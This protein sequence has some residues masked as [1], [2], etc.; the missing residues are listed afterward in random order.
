MEQFQA[1]RVQVRRHNGG[2]PFLGRHLRRLL[3]EAGFARA[4][5]RAFVSSAGSPEETRRHAAFFKALL[6]GLARTAIAEGW[7]DQATVDA[8]VAEI[9]AWAVRPDAFHAGI[10]CEVVGWVSD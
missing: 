5:A 10:A 9:D 1:L 3:V 8:M 7:V 4:E 6:P 2:D